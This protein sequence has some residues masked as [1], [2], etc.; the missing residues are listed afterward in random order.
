MHATASCNQLIKLK[1][2][3]RVGLIKKHDLCFMCMKKGHIS[4]FCR[5]VPECGKCGK[6]HNTIFHG[7]TQPAKKGLN[8]DAAAFVQ[9]HAP[10]NVQ[11]NQSPSQDNDLMNLEEEIPVP[12]AASTPNPQRGVVQDNL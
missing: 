1:P 10:G 6:P 4:R 7:R 2:D 5:N 3:D 11:G 12:N 8:V 9:Q